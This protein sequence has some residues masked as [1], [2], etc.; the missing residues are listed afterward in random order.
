MREHEPKIKRDE[1][2]SETGKITN[3]G[4]FSHFQTKNIVFTS[5]AYFFDR[6]PF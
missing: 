6:V 1:N 3:M 4:I 5:E 2:E